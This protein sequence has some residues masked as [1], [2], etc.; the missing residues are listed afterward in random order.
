VLY[1][2]TIVVWSD[3]DKGLIHACHAALQMARQY[4]VVVYGMELR[5]VA[6]PD[7]DPDYDTPVWETFNQ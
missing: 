2:K 3:S 6:N 5:E 7:T 1:K 4:N